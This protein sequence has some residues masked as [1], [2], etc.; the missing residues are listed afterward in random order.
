MDLEGMD[1]KAA[2]AAAAN[3]L[4]AAKN[5][6]FACTAELE[7]ARRKELYYDRLLYNLR[8]LQELLKNEGRELDEEDSRGGP[9]RLG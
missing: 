4:D 6:T 7:A 8:Y 3:N 5:N 2:I 9:L 1:L